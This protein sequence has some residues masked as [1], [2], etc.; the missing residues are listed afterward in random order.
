M[1]GSGAGRQV[2]FRRRRGYEP[3]R[4]RAVRRVRRALGEAAFG[5]MQVC[6]FFPPRPI[7]MR[8]RVHPDVP[9]RIRHITRHGR[10]HATAAIV[11]AVSST[12]AGRHVGPLPEQV[13]VFRHGPLPLSS[14][15][16]YC[17]VTSDR[18]VGILS[19]SFVH[20]SARRRRNVLRLLENVAVK[21]PG[22]R[23]VPTLAKRDLVVDTANPTG[24]AAC[25]RQSPKHRLAAKGDG[26]GLCRKALQTGVAT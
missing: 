26:S 22:N 16:P 3:S 4:N 13:Y 9:N 6:I 17:T 21:R 12:T 5:I 1:A 23:R 11:N 2:F 20:P 18:L 10:P 8:S 25:H 7:A 19:S 24:R 15:L 14:A